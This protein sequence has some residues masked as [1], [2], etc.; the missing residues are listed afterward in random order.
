MS[1]ISS[2]AELKEAIQFLEFEKEAIRQELKENVNVITES[3]RPVN[4]IKSTMSDV[5]S[6]DYI[7]DNMVGTALGIGTGYISRKLII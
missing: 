7:I 1:K 2:S 3:L 5:A 4:L 6:S